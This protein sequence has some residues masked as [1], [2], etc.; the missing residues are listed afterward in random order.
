MPFIHTITTK[1]LTNEQKEELKT[2]FGRIIEDIPGKSEDWLMLA[3]SDG[4][5][6]YFRGDGDGD[7]AFIDVKIFGTAP[8]EAYEAMTRDVCALIEGRL[9]IPAD[10]VYVKYEEA[11]KWGWNG[12]NF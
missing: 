9:G 3:F 10:R 6:M 5:E 4:V 1:K 12:A 8:S 2:E 7:A 11:D